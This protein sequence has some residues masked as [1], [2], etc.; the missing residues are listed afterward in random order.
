[1]GSDTN[2]NKCSL[3]VKMNGRVNS[4]GKR[5]GPNNLCC[6]HANTLMWYRSLSHSNTTPSYCSR[7][8]ACREGVH[9]CG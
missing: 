6:F 5:P 8:C 3:S 9:E 1:M 4:H 2:E 7:V